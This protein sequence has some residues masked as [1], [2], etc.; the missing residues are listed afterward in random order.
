VTGEA[1]FAL[2][3]LLRPRSIAIIGISPEP[4]S[5]GGAVLANLERFGYGGDIHLVSRNR[6]R[7]DQR[8][9]VPT[10][11][12]L[13]AGIDAA[14]LAV[15]GDAIN[16]AV[17]A[18]V[19]RRVGAAVVYAAGFAE[20]G[21]TGRAVQEELAGIAR[22]GG[23]ALC[24]PNCVGLVNFIDGIPLTYEPIAPL[25]ERGGPAIGIIGQSGAMV[26][27]LRLALLAKGLAISQSISTGNEAVLGCEDFL[28]GLVDDPRTRA[29]VM[30]AEQIR[31]PQ[32]FLAIATRARAAK[33]PIVLMHPGRSRRARVSASSHTGALVADHAVMRTMVGDHAVILV[34]TTEELIDTA[35][36]LARF[37]APAAGA[38]IVTNSGAFKGFALD[39]CEANGLDL[40]PLR[41]P[42]QDA[43]RGVLPSFASIDNP[44]DTT[45]QTIKAPE[46]FTGST[47]HLLADPAI[48]SLIVSIVPGGPTQAME[49]TK[50]LLPPLAA[51][52]KPVAVAVMGDEVPLP[53]EFIAAFRS[54][55]I[56][57]FRSPERALRAMAHATAYGRKLAAA[58]PAVAATSLPPLRLE[59]AGIY[60]EYEGKALM[61][62]LGIATPRG[63][64]AKTAADAQRIAAEI[65]YPVVLKAQSAALA[66]KSEAGGVILGIAD[67]DGL[68][69]AWDRLHRNVAV[70]HPS[71]A[72]DGVLVEAMSR[73]GLE[74]VVGGRRDPDWGPVVMC[75]LGGIWIEVL[76]DVRLMPA[77]L[78]AA[79]VA[80]ELA[81]LKAAHLLKGTRSQP[82][83]DIDALVHTIT[84]IG[85]LLRAHP[86]I[87]EIDINPLVVYPD[88]VVALD[89]L[90]VTRRYG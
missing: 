49:K 69:A 79:S 60:P 76:N 33:K 13:P 42:T 4:G 46:I 35:E 44:L 24:G 39:F 8:T 9:C 75:G 81:Q 86:Q 14:V 6:D 40:P 67:R 1:G 58:R 73:P 16:D 78:D 36:I 50:A 19:R 77:D 38:A 18:C 21:A 10:I 61:T 80:A 53:A 59:R 88:G 70:A 64:L 66:H 43:L 68:A 51:S 30:F 90:L 31:Q 32:R 3:R 63:E 28:S 34:D 47:R 55:G 26:A 85:A 56:P 72:L 37:P 29:I 83:G 62:A 15:P 22:T 12:D 5:I 89:V 2:G 23:L 41:A 17:A 45:G 84:Q 87:V 25:T 57:F 65:G 20:R 7:I 27:S 11:D 54:N 52:A 71:L 48:G 82:P 74:F